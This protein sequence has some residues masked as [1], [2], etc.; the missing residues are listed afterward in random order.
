M[1]MHNFYFTVMETTTSSTTSTATNAFQSTPTTTTKPSTL[2]STPST[3]KS[4]PSTTVVHTTSPLATVQ[5]TTKDISTTLRAT[6]ITR[7]SQKPDPT[8]SYVST[9][10]QTTQSGGS[11]TSHRMKTTAS[12]SMYN[13]RNLP[14]RTFWNSHFIWVFYVSITKIMFQFFQPYAHEETKLLTINCMKG[15]RRIFLK[16]GTFSVF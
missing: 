16:A 12:N 11:T 8:D 9:S 13:S 10:A 4:A 3:N 1:Y 7:S 6:K 5:P 14:Q 15:T 2:T